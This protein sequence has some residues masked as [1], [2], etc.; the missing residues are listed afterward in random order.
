MDY[1][2]VY[3]GAHKS[4]PHFISSQCKRLAR[5]Q[6]GSHLEILIQYWCVLCISLMGK[7]YLH[8]LQDWTHDLTL[9]PLFMGQGDAIG[10]K[11]SYKKHTN[12]IIITAPTS[13]AIMTIANQIILGILTPNANVDSWE[14]RSV[15]R[16]ANWSE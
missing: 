12:I 6:A 14:H 7:H 9:D 5:I 11:D 1:D 16:P 3:I 10:S 2:I 13:T 8:A 4:F 15:I